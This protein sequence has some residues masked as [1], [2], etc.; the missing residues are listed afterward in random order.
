MLERV[1][2]NWKYGDVELR[3]PK[4]VAPLLYV[5]FHVSVLFLQLSSQSDLQYMHASL[6]FLEI[7]VWFIHVWLNYS[8]EPATVRHIVD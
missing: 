7:P 1:P 8:D 5:V 4:K 2:K 6:F 3:S